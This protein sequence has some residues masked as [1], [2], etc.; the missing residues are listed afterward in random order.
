MSADTS[1]IVPDGATLIAAERRRQ[2][3]AEG[4]TPEHDD[5]HDL[6]ELLAA[7]RAYLTAAVWAV[8]P[9][10]AFDAKSYPPSTWP[11]HASWWKPSEDP[12]RNLI[13]AGALIAAEIDRL[14]RAAATSTSPT[15][16]QP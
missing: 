4:W 1:E 6:C 13:K 14:Q 12:I 16:G 8:L 11:W 15:G 7:A 5:E 9:V 2:M 10:P 3:E